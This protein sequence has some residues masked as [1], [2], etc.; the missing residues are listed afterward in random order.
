MADAVRNGDRQITAAAA[1]GDLRH[2]RKLAIDRLDEQ[3]RR[4]L[5]QR[6]Q[7]YSDAG[8]RPGVGRRGA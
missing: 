8:P 1:K 4:E 5:E 3:Q 2:A 7:G 6:M